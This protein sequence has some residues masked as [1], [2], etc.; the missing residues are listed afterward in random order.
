MIAEVVADVLLGLGV[1][2]I[3]ASSLG[4]ALLDDPLHRLHLVTPAA[5]LGVPLVC[6]AVV[7]RDGL[8]AS[9]LAALAVAVLAVVT[10]PLLAQALARSIEVR[11]Q[12]EGPR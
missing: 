8:D 3:A 1:A 10:S 2:V 4:M 9:G 11:R 7:V 12:A 6:A 5:V